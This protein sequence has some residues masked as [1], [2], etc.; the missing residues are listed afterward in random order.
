M[1]VYCLVGPSAAGKSTALKL[2]SD[3]Y[4]VL[5]ERY[6][7]LNI[8]N[9]DNRLIL[10]KWKY[11][12]YWFSSILE[13]KKKGYENLITDRC[14][15]DTCAYI[16]NM[17]NELFNCIDESFKEILHLGI[18]TKFILI[19]ADFDELERRINNRILLEKDRVNYNEL[20]QEHNRRAYDFFIEKRNIWDAEINTSDNK[21]A[22][23][24]EKI[25]K[26]I[27]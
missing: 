23:V 22:D 4:K 20:D 5:E 15:F 27:V 2:L 6:M 9:L 13:A 3:N 12:D 10:S 16:S 19:N 18:S 8:F 11:I 24:V 14:P 26:I 1:K 21:P 17:K 7:D 25:E